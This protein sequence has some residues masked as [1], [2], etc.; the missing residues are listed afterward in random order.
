MEAL[1]LVDGA[2]QSATVA[3]RK[4]DTA[5][6]AA[7]RSVAHM[8]RRLVTTPGLQAADKAGM[9]A[10]VGAAEQAAKAAERKADEACDGVIEA[11]EEMDTVSRPSRYPVLCQ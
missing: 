9:Q 2:C 3:N 6:E 1:E 8:V 10:R 7:V 11:R 4:L 5:L